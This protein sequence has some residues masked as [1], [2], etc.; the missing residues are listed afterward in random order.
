MRVSSPSSVSSS[1]P[2]WRADTERQ[3]IEGAGTGIELGVRGRGR[4]VVPRLG[5]WAR[6]GGRR[7]IGREGIDGLDDGA[8]EIDQ[9]TGDHGRDEAFE[10]ELRDLLR[11]EG[12]QGARGEWSGKTTDF[13]T[14]CLDGVALTVP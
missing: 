1:A 4:G 7:G 5:V 14:G 11:Y 13:A 3:C 12:V 10:L 9:V 8:V 6:E 2:G